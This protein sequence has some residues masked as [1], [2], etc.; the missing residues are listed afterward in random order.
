MVAC[1]P[2]AG[3]PERVARLEAEMALATT[4]PPLLLQGD[5]VEMSS[6]SMGAIYE[7]PAIAGIAAAVRRARSA[8]D[9]ENWASWWQ[10][11]EA[12]GA[13]AHLLDER[14]RRVMSKEGDHHVSVSVH[15]RLLRRAGFHQVGTIWQMGDDRILVAIR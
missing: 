15:E 14:R 6:G 10:A 13:F 7:Q 11:I 9:N 5:A 12:D 8:L 1:L 2:V 3:S 4:A